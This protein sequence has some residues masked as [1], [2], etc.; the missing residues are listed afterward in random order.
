[1][2]WREDPTPY[3]V[4]LSEIMLQ[5][6]RVEA[7][8]G[9]YSRFLETLPDVASL[10]SASEDTC[11]K[12]WEGLGY[13]SRVRNLRKAACEVMER[14]GG[15]IPDTAAGLIKLPGI[16]KYTAAAIA[17]I[18]F[19]ERI[20]AIDGNLL[21]IYARLAMYEDN[22]RTPAAQKRASEYFENL[23]PESA[24]V[25]GRENPCGDFNQA[26]MDLGSTVCLPGSAACCGKC[27]AADFCR[28]HKERPG[29]EAELPF[30][31]AAAEKKIE[32]LTVFIIRNGEK[33]AV[34]KRSSKGLLA[35]LYEFPN[36]AGALD[37]KE[38]AA[39][40]RKNHVEPLRIRRICDA[41]H[42][43][44]HKKWIMRGYEVLTDSLAESPIPFI[45]ADREE[46]TGKYCI[47]SAFSGYLEWLI[48]AES[49]KS[50]YK[51]E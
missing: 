6:T 42:I 23:M 19:G 43:F 17:S 26:L 9:Y 11:L 37:D 33:T 35:G 27:P 29:R 7:V 36:A 31:P 15:E 3:H 12:L 22:I 10:A 5:Q 47:P 34:R 20:P 40:L 18:A 24:A 38:A 41:D 48:A 45:M 49:G 44:T 25:K 28:T 2:P 1:M 21:R 30:I 50:S 46:I 8:K 32:L 39:W 13:Y 14:C 4:W 51:A 16:G